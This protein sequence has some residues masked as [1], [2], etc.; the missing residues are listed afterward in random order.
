MGRLITVQ[1]LE[2]FYAGASGHPFL[3]MSE[4]VAIKKDTGAITSTLGE[5]T[6]NA[7]YGAQVWAQLNMEANAFGVLPKETWIRSGWRVITN[8]AWMNGGTDNMGDWAVGETD[9]LPDA[10]RPPIEVV[11]TRPKFVV[12]TFEVSDVIEALAEVSEDDVY[13][14]AEHLR[15]H[16]GD[17]HRKAINRFIMKRV[18]PTASGTGGISYDTTVNITP[19][20]LIVS[21]Y[22][23]VN[24]LGYDPATSVTPY[25]VDRSS[26]DSWANAYVNHNAGTLRTLTDDLIRESIQGVREKGGNTTVIL[27]GYDTYYRLQGEYMNYVRYLPMG[28]TQVQFGLNGIQ[29]AKGVDAGVKVASLYGIPLITAVDT[30]KDDAGLSRI[31]LLD[32]SDAEGYG[33]SR[34][35]F[36]VARPTEYF[37]TRDFL[38]LNKFVVKGAYRTVGDLACRFFPAQGKIR[39]L[40]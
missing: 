19:L 36:M 8:F 30:P 39:D 20:D 2:L 31:Y 7:I 28:E 12:N 15:R 33:M 40:Q 21:S 35:G 38:L 32:T 18:I 34:L 23:E 26:A 13:G 6:W 14:T 17:L 5:Q 4:Y 10:V 9:P 37:E 3:D 1:D 25:G 24:S 11:K 27:T 16:Y 22:D 29:T